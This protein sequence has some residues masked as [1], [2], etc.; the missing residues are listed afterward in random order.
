MNFRVFRM[1][2]FIAALGIVAAVMAACGGGEPQELDIQ[3]E[4]RGDTLVPETIKVKHND[5]V[6]LRIEAEKSGEFHIHG[7]DMKKDV[8]GGELADLAFEA[9]LEG[10]FPITFHEQPEADPAH[11]EGSEE[12]H[13]DEEGGEGEEAEEEHHDEGSEEVEIGSLEVSPR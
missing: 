11:E 9:T 6:T 4:V 8:T 10:R 3:V 1:A 12:E 13:P 5:M 2:T 7:Y